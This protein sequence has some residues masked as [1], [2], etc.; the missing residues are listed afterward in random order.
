M[1][2][3][4]T[5]QSQPSAL[6]CLRQ[7]DGPDWAEERQKLFDV[8]TLGVLKFGLDFGPKLEFRVFVQQAM[9]KNWDLY[10]HN[11]TGG[12]LEFRSDTNPTR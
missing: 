5:G 12:I 10:I 4:S 9:S 8:S 1:D 3:L 6:A 2:A 11:F 7:Y